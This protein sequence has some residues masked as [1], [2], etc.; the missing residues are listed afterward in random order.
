MSWSCVTDFFEGFLFVGGKEEVAGCCI[1]C[2]LVEAIL[3]GLST[4]EKGSGG[5]EEEG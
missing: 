1:S 2:V 5:F 4:C 3:E